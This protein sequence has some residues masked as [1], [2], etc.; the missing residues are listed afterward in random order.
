MSAIRSH[1]WKGDALLPSYSFGA[2]HI[3]GFHHRPLATHGARAKVKSNI[4]DALHGCGRRTI[5]L[6]LVA[7]RD[8]F[9]TQRRSC[10]EF[11]VDS[12]I[13]RDMSSKP[14]V[15][16][17]VSIVVFKQSSDLSDGELSAQ[18]KYEFLIGISVPKMENMLFVDLWYTCH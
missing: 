6:L 13:C 16:C 7:E 14:F 15:H 8:Y 3:Q 4:A 9:P 1:H 12:A 11:S 17:K 5:L 10:C 2:G 18:I